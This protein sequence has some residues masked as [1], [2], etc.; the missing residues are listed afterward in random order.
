MVFPWAM[1]VLPQAT[2][3]LNSQC[4]EIFHKIFNHYFLDFKGK[5]EVFFSGFHF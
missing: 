1:P 3:T 2:G 4:V 5:N